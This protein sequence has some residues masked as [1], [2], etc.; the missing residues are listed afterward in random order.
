MLSKDDFWQLQL[1]TAV[2]HAETGVC[3]DKPDQNPP[4]SYA[5]AKRP[6]LWQS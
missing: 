5:E 3:R 2:A 6:L 4:G 1:H